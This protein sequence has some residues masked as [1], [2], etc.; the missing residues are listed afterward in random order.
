MRTLGGFV[1]SKRSP[2]ALQSHTHGVTRCRLR[3]F[4]EMASSSSVPLPKRRRADDVS[5]IIAST[6]LQVATQARQHGVSKRSVAA[7]LHKFDDVVTPYG[8]LY[9]K[10]PV[11]VAGKEDLQVDCVNP[12]AFIWHVAN[13]SPAAA[14]FFRQWLSGKVCRIAIHNDNVKLGSVLRPDRGRTFEAFYWTFLEFPDWFRSKS[15]L[16]WFVF[17]FVEAVNLVEIPGA[18]AVVA[19]AVVRVFSRHRGKLATSRPLACCSNAVLRKCTCE[20]SSAACSAM[21]RQSRRWLVARVPPGK[22]PAL[23]AKTSST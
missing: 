7:E 13:T 6:G 2:T 4:C 3:S 17:C 18:L 12:Y 11:P 15:S 14:C 23:I 8:N 22:N 10:F 1:P 19:K 20:L 9:M 21:R 5:A 16:S